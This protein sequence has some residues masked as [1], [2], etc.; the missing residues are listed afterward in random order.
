MGERHT[1]VSSIDAYIA[2]FPGAVQAQLQALRSAIRAAA[3]EAEEAISYGMPTFRLKGNLVHFA[4]FTHHIG[5][6]PTPSGIAAFQDALSGYRA[7]KGS[8][9]FPVDQPLPLELIADIV[10]F[11]AAENRA[12]AEAKARRGGSTRRRSGEEQG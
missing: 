2:A 11:R 12:A 4:A 7:A 6:Y 10:R 3:P 8:V 9:Q 5:F 1:G